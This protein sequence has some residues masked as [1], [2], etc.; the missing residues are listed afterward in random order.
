MDCRGRQPGA[1]SQLAMGNGAIGWM[2]VPG[3]LVGGCVLG[4]GGSLLFDR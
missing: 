2:G 4:L 1:K 3:G